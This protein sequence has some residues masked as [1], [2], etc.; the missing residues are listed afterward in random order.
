MADGGWRM[1][2]ARFEL[3]HLGC[4]EGKIYRLF[5]ELGHVFLFNHG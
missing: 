4:R 3:R 1:A 2:G 5:I